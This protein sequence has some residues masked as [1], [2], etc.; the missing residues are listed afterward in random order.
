MA[1]RLAEVAAMGILAVHLM[2][3]S[4]RCREGE[5]DE[6]FHSIIGK[7]NQLYPSTTCLEVKY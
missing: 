1:D 6:F 4:V 7:D 5:D 2:T 3:D